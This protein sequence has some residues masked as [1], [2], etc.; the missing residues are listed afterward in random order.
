LKEL[1][2]DA[3]NADLEA[4]IRSK[5]GPAAVPGNMSVAKSGILKELRGG[6]ARRKK[7]GRPPAQGP[8]PAPLATTAA[9]SSSEKVPLSDL[10]QVKELSRRLGKDRLKELA[11]LIG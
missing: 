8:K 5:H 6:K 7:R 1:G 3:K 2:H 11:D 4:H 10:R 9:A